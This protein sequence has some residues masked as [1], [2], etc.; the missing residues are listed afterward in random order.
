M[1]STI[2][3]VVDADVLIED[4][5]IVYV[6]PRRRDE[7]DAE[8]IDASN[9]IIVPGFVDGHRHTWEVLLR[10]VSADWT[11]GHYYQG[12]RG[13]L[14]KHFSA[15]DLYIAN[16]LGILDGLDGGVTTTLDWCHNINTPEHADAA[17]QAL[18]D[19]G[20][21]AVFGYGNSND[22]WLPVSDVPHSRDAQRLREQ[23]FSSDDGL[24]TMQ[25]AI[26]GPQ[27]ATMTVTEH[28][29]TLSRELALR[30][31]MSVG[32]GEWG[33]N[34]P[35][36]ALHHK[37][38]MGEDVGYVHCTSLADDELQL[39]AETGGATVLSPDL[40]AQMW[41]APATG[42]LLDLG[43]EPSL[44]VD[45]TT[46]ISGDMFGVMRTTLVVERAR[47]HDAA[48]ARGEV[49]Q[50]LPLTARQ[51]LRLATVAG[52]RF[53]GL[54]DRVGSITPGKQADLVLIAG[55]TLA[56]TP[57]NNPVGA[58][59]LVAGRGDVDAVVV[60]GQFVKRD[61]K[62]LRDDLGSLRE[63]ALRSRDRVFAAAQ[64]PVPGDWMPSTYAPSRPARE[65]QESA[66]KSYL[67]EQSF[68]RRPSGT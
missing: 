33:R 68:Y 15:E 47:Q 7:I 62:L 6:G 1:D 31:S 66:A 59:A 2:G 40:E 3:D 61:G 32:D 20:A 12:L 58:V 26:R 9:R 41:G 22:E 35:I 57:L 30:M 11:L 37:G 42:R 53:C 46:S 13:A 17:V 45:C 14:A 65:M 36:R 5:A 43:V 55:D 39:I 54:D 25:M 50:Q 21:R 16:L 60:A 52:A 48:T 29:M 67:A 18:R 10:G 24:I 38:L 8:I 19:S 34:G 56:M 49:L 51:T 63:Q 23:Y 27:Y 44:S 4:N 28:D 64:I